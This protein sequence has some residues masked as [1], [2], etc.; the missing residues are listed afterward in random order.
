M[1]YNKIIIRLLIIMMLFA[2]ND[3]NVCAMDG[4]TTNPKKVTVE[5]IESNEE[6]IEIALIN[7]GE[8][9]FHYWGGFVLEKL[10]GHKWQEMKMIEEIYFPKTRELKSNEIKIIKI[11]WKDYYGKNL[12]KGNYRIEIVNMMEFNIMDKFISKT[13][14]P[15]KLNPI[16]D[17]YLWFKN[18]ILWIKNCNMVVNK[19]KKN[20]EAGNGGVARMMTLERL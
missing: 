4:I 9:Y 13:T 14:L 18:D 12:T 1:I 17:I 20:Y 3:M 6:Y 19:I 16:S 11:K 15:P 2:V 7:K 10:N 5:I 8:E